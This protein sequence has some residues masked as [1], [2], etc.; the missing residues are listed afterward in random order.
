MFLLNKTHSTSRKVKCI[1]MFFTYSPNFSMVL[2]KYKYACIQFRTHKCIKYIWNFCCFR[3]VYVIIYTHIFNIAY[4]TWKMVRKKALFMQLI[5]YIHSNIICVF[6]LKLFCSLL[7]YHL[8]AF[9]QE[10][11][12]IHTLQTLQK[13][14][15][16]I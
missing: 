11:Y 13:S 4:L 8:L 15:Y 7:P 9:F 5:E 10:I 1:F 2:L 3:L 12:S 6:K 16:S 14:V